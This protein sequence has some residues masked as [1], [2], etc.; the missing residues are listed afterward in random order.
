[1]SLTASE[2]FAPDSQQQP[3]QQPQLKQ[4]QHVCHGRFPVSHE[5]ATVAWQRWRDNVTTDASE[6]RFEQAV[7]HRAGT[8]RRPSAVGRCD[9][10]RRVEQEPTKLSRSSTECSQQACLKAFGC[11]LR[12]HAGRDRYSCND[13]LVQAIRRACNFGENVDN[14]A[15]KVLEELLCWCKAVVQDV[16]EGRR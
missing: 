7:G 10:D 6:T 4:Q 15:D 8:G 14:T 1:M 13:A 5:R 9:V 11:C 3:Q 2:A 16:P 12:R